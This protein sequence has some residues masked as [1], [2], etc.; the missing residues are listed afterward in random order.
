[1]VTAG[2]DPGTFNAEVVDEA[3]NRY[4]SLAGYRT[5]EFQKVE[6]ARP[7]TAL[8]GVTA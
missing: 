5:A 1:M 4:V 6:L 3:G 7:P 8:Q 2:A